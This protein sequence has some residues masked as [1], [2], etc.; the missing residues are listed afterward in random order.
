VKAVGLRKTLIEEMVEDAK[1]A[2]GLADDNVELSEE[3]PEVAREA[4]ELVDSLLAP[5]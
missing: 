5:T 3:G 4:T 1:E 2:T